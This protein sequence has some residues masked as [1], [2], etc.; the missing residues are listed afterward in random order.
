MSDRNITAKR[1]YSQK[2]VRDWNFQKKK[3]RKK[4]TEEK[5]QRRIAERKF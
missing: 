3:K 1:R 4:E 5:K 2:C